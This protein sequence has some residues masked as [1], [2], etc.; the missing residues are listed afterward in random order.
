MLEHYE[1][2]LDHLYSCRFSWAHSILVSMYSHTISFHHLS[3]NTRPSHSTDKHSPIKGLLLSPDDRHLLILHKDHSIHIWNVKS[4]QRLHPSDN[5]IADFSESIHMEYAPDSSRVLVRDENKL[6]VLQYTTGHIEWI[7]VVPR[8]S[9]KLLAAT[10]FRDSN[11]VL[12][13][14]MDGNVT[15]VSLRDMSRYS[16]P[17][18]CSQLTNIRQLVISPTEELLSICSNSGLIIQGTCQDIERSILSN[19]V[20]SAIFS[21]DGTCLLAG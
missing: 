7:P 1:F 21:P 10:F 13:I 15:A 12:I 19:G 9:S 14:K 5:Q 17:H 3:H 16:M 2:N 6:M 20:E 4:D 8:S 11:R 18:L